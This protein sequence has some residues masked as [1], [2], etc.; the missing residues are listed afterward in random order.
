[1]D[2]KYI[3]NAP[4]DKVVV[5]PARLGSAPANMLNAR[6][7]SYGNTKFKAEL[8]FDLEDEKGAGAQRE[9]MNLWQSIYFPLVNA[10]SKEDLTK[11]QIDTI[12]IKTGKAT[13]DDWKKAE[14]QKGT[15]D[16]E[17]FFEEGTKN[18]VLKTHN[19]MR[20]NQKETNATTGAKNKIF[21]RDMEGREVNA[22]T[23]GTLIKAGDYGDFLLRYYTI[24]G[25]GKDIFPRA[26]FSL[27]GF[28]KTADG[29]AIKLGSFSSDEEVAAK[30][31]KK[32][33]KSSS[34]ATDDADL[35]ADEVNDLLG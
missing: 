30:F 21:V 24:G 23:V 1:M 16:E 3:I 33:S 2:Y 25:A 31:F 27:V 22:A 7:D 29:K 32:P 8:L 20:V 17:K 5:V 10:E 35:S 13:L 9:L 15:Y 28:Q 11:E 14:K 26:V 19:L 12:P 4:E 34:A 18:D 6:L